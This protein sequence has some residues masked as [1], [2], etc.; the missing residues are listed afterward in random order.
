M[1]H[2]QEPW[3]DAVGTRA[4]QQTSA[5]ALNLRLAFLHRSTRCTRRLILHRNTYRNRSLVPIPWRLLLLLLTYA[6]L[7]VHWGAWRNAQPYEFV[8]PRMETKC[9][10]VASFTAGPFVRNY[11]QKRYRNT[12]RYSARA[13]LQCFLYKETV[14]HTTVSV[15]LCQ[16]SSWCCDVIRDAWRRIVPWIY[17][18]KPC[19]SDGHQLKC[20][21]Q[22]RLSIASAMTVSFAETHAPAQADKTISEFISYTHT[23]HCFGLRY[24]IFPLLSLWYTIGTEVLFEIFL[25]YRKIIWTGFLMSNNRWSA[26]YMQCFTV[27]FLLSVKTN[28]CSLCRLVN[29]WA[30]NNL[31]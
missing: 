4:T 1:S 8:S 2:I 5:A 3:R 14:Q 23:R 17:S 25:P 11:D 27:Y 22:L 10:L 16:Q 30:S 21:S 29:R 24:L 18:W 13:D 7:A 28:R 20:E 15:P 9:A 26:F 12:G 6:R 19:F 31:K